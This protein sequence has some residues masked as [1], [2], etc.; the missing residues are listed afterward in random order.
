MYTIQNEVNDHII[1]HF[2]YYTFSKDE[3]LHNFNRYFGPFDDT[4]DLSIPQGN[5]SGK[6]ILEIFSKELV[7]IQW[8]DINNTTQAHIGED[9]SHTIPIQK[10]DE[11]IDVIRFVKTG[12]NVLEINI[13]FHSLWELLF[14]QNSYRIS[15]LSI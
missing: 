9:P 4:V 11:Q 12:Q 3:D 7:S 14:Y 15:K 5:Y 8:K 13:K 2:Q 6:E 10:V 1:V